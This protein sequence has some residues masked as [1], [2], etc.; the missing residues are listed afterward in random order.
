MR[1]SVNRHKLVD[2]IEGVAG[3]V[4]VEAID[5]QHQLRF[6]AV[7]EIHISSLAFKR[8]GERVGVTLGVNHRNPNQVQR[9]DCSGISLTRRLLGRQL[10][11]SC[12]WQQQRCDDGNDYQHQQQLQQRKTFHP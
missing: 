11:P 10:C 7:L 1:G 5:K 3:V 4:A 12:S 9:L 8:R 2:K 6:F